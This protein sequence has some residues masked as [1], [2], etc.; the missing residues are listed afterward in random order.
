MG[1][2][3]FR[4][5]T[6]R[7]A[8]HDVSLEFLTQLSQADTTEMLKEAGMDN[9]VH[10]H[11]I[12]EALEG[13]SEDLLSDSGLQSDLGDTGEPMY[14]V[15]LTYPR[16]KGEELASLIQIQLETRGFTVY[17]DSHIP[18]SVLEKT[19]SMVRD[20][21]NFLLILCPGALDSVEED[22]RLHREIETALQA[23]TVR[24][25]S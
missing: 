3:E 13:L 10:R 11:R 6:Y 5:Y 15:Y 24:A 1:G 8:T 4:G 12:L 18:G 14:D 20:T 16:G 7:L 23:E 9:S 19:L 2:P 17:S 22:V 25:I 21:K